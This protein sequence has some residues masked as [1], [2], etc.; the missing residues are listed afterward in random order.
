MGEGL[1]A[2][3]FLALSHIEEALEKRAKAQGERAER[4]L[5]ENLTAVRSRILCAR[6]SVLSVLDMID[7]HH[8]RITKSF[9]FSEGGIL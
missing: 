8:E 3:Y 1:K 7:D 5:A 2:G 6:A 4:A 9:D